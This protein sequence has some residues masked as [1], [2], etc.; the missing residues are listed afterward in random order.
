[1]ETPKALFEFLEHSAAVDPD[2][3]AVIEP[4]QGSITYGKLNALADQL[5]DRLYQLGVRPGDRVGI[6]LHK[7][8]DCLADIFGGL[9]TGAAYVPLDPGAPASR[10]AYILSDCQMKAVVIENCFVNNLAS[11]GWIIDEFRNT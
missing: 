8:I 2:R 10:N 5:R 3:T 11:G 4:G 7:S 6:Y 9:E 1:M